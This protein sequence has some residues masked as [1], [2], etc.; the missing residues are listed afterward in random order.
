MDT[1]Q[2]ELE[3]LAYEASLRALTH[4]E[5]TL[6]QLQGRTG[7]LLAA[8]SVAASFLGAQSIQRGRF[9]VFAV[10]AVAAFVV[11][12]VISVSILLPRAKWVFALQGPT[13]TRSSMRGA[14]IHRRSTGGSPIGSHRS[15][16]RIRKSLIRS[17]GDIDGRHRHSFSKSCSGSPTSAISSCSDGQQ[18]SRSPATSASAATRARHTRDTRRQRRSGQVTPRRGPPPRPAKAA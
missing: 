6:D 13:L 18:T 10:A 11:S 9:G 16:R 2:P 7:T 17:T 12:I 3:R 5:S 14:G 1:P 8:S 4:Q 15:G